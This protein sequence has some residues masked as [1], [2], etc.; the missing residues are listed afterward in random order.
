MGLAFRQGQSLERSCG[1]DMLMGAA[2]G[3]DELTKGTLIEMSRGPGTESWNSPA[4]I[5]QE[6]EEKPTKED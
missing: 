4:F 6:G 3:V 5:G 2:M 1:V